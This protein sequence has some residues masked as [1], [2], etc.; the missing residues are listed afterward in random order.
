MEAAHLAVGW[1]GAT[2][3]PRA[4]VQRGGWRQKNPLAMKMAFFIGFSREKA[5]EGSGRQTSGAWRQNRRWTQ[6]DGAVQHTEPTPQTK[7]HKDKG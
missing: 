2:G 4:L 3:G 7:E 5:Y 6:D 1:S